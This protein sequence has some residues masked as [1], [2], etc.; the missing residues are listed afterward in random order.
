[1]AYIEKMKVTQSCL[2]LRDSMDYTVHGILQARILEWVAYPFSRG[3][4]QPRVWTQDSHI[5]DRFFISWATR[6]AQPIWEKNLKTSG[7]MY[8][9]WLRASQMTQFSLVQWLSHVQLFVTDSMDC[10][11]PGFPIHHQLLDPAQTLVH[12]VIDT[13]QS[14]HPLSS[15]GK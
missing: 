6:K 7:Y 9:W 12:W 13:I 14:S 4:S 8:M 10:S 2:T 3:S 5:A 1:M 11:T 15:S